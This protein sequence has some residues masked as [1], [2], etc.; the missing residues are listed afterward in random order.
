MC[1]LKNWIAYILVKVLSVIFCLM[2]AEFALLVARTIARIVYPFSFKYKTIAYGNIRKAFVGIKS[3]R[4]MRVILKKSFINLI[5]DVVECL[6]FPRLDSNY[7]KKYIRLEGIEDIDKALEEKHGVILVGSHFGS[8]EMA[9]VVFSLLGYDHNVFAKEQKK[10]N[11]LFL[12]LNELRK[13]KGTKVFLNSNALLG[14][15]RALKHN[16]V[17]AMV[18]DHGGK[19]ATTVPFFNIPTPT[20]SGAVRLA[21]RFG[22]PV[23]LGSITR[24]NGPY[25]L[26]KLEPVSIKK[27]DS[28]DESLKVNLTRINSKLEEL[29]ISSPQDNLWRYRRWKYSPFKKVLILSDAKQGHLNQSKAVLDMIKAEHTSISSNIIEVKFKSNIL[30]LL[31][32]TASLFICNYSIGSL[33]I[34]KLALR[35]ESFEALLSSQADIIISAGSSLAAVNLYL[36]RENQAKSICLMN[37]GFL[38]RS[39]FDLIIVPVH[40]RLLHK[41]NTVLTDAAVNRISEGYLVEKGAKLQKALKENSINL[42]TQV[43]GVFFGGDSK[44][45]KYEKHDLV[46]FCQQINQFLENSGFDMLFTTSRRTSSWQEEVFEEQLKGHAKFMIVANKHNLEYAFG[47]ILAAS[48]IVLVSAESISMVSEAV[49]SLKKVVVFLPSVLRLRNRHQTFLDNLINKGLVI[50]ADENNLNSVLNSVLSKDY[51]SLQINDRD[52]ITNALRKKI[53]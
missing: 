16:K 18:A 53:L 29:I 20:P 12:Y 38:R 32:R 52:V 9:N 24:I 4:E 15:A 1:F 37:P 42:K 35:K 51:M 19:G 27:L 43:L 11:K 22:S 6:R 49:S 46:G 39:L 10:F 28:L 33:G 17:V 36:K 25:H 41:T 14:I 5:Q 3:Q 23:L 30:R 2:S 13:S 50:V 40:D 45:F 34:L 7:I 8:W 47:G 26:L 48:R 44:S 21:L 31:A